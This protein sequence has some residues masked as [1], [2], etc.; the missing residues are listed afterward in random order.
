MIVVDATVWVSRLVRG[1]DYH[2]VT[3][4]WLDAAAARNERIVA[5]ALVLA[6]IAGAISRRTGN[7]ALGARAA[8][9]F[10]QLSFLRLLRMDSRLAVTAARVA[11][12]LHLRG[13]D[14]VY[15]AIALE[16]GIPLLTW[17]AV[18]RERAGGV[19]DVRTP[20]AV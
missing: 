12:E 18:Q 15:V 8:A 9:S 19:I 3:R 6:E 13:A 20:A 7:P 5:P 2:N 11:A 4:R 10:Q 14:A 16:L 17:D 1:D